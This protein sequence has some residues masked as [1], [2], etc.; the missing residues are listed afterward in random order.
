MGRAKTYERTD[1]TRKAMELFWRHG[2][3]A[4]STKAL[5]QHMGINVYSLFAE[6]ES[7]QGL[8]EAALALYEKEVV[9]QR[10][11]ALQRSDAGIAEILALLDVFASSAGSKDA[12]KGCFMCNTATERSPN[13]LASRESVMSNFKS[14]THAINLALENSKQRGDICPTIRCED[15][16]KALT[17]TLVGLQVLMRAGTDAA[18]IIDAVRAARAHVERLR[19]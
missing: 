2:F 3:E 9:S 19:R 18:F 13:D 10:F 4:T 5:A 1:V 15:E 17:A 11:D 6:F 14:N 12:A 8:Y 7:K 16:S